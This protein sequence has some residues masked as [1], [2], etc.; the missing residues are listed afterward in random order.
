LYVE[1]ARIGPSSPTVIVPESS[2]CMHDLMTAAG[3]REPF[4]REGNRDDGLGI[5]VPGGSLAP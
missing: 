1:Y 2:Q 3:V 5:F 4:G